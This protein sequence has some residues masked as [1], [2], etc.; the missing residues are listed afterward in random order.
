M[1]SWVYA[2]DEESGCVGET[3]DALV[4]EIAY[5]PAMY[6]PCTIEHAWRKGSASPR[7][8]ADGDVGSA[9]FDACTSETTATSIFSPFCSMFISVMR[10]R[11]PT[12]YAKQSASPTPYAPRVLSVSCLASKGALPA[13]SEAS[14]YL[15]MTCGSTQ[16]RSVASRDLKVDVVIMARRKSGGGGARV[17]EG[18]EDR[19][20]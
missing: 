14:M 11:L 13:T 15:G 6:G 4:D 20:E 5:A 7:T 12:V 16:P 8:D 2:R 3:G 18:R 19:R 10:M 1:R 17:S 9:P